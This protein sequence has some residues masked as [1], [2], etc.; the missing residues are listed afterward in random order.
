MEILIFELLVVFAPHGSHVLANELKYFRTHRNVIFT[1]L[2]VYLEVRNFSVKAMSTDLC[3]FKN[4]YHGLEK[5]FHFPGNSQAVL[6]IKNWRERCYLPS[7]ADL[8]PLSRMFRT[9]SYK[10]CHGTFYVGLHEVP[11]L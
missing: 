6:Q 5:Y 4:C 1:F 3:I 9:T 8:T 10:L 2:K 7:D 11:T